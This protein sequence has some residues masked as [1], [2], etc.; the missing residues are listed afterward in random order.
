MLE[1]IYL[2]LAVFGVLLLAAIVAEIIV[3]TSKARVL[4]TLLS[5]AVWAA[6]SFAAQG[7]DV[8]TDSGGT[9]TQQ[10][11]VMIVLA[12]ALT[13]FSIAELL[14]AIAAKLSGSEGDD[15]VEQSDFGTAPP[16]R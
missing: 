15:P 9:V 13:L 4:L 11:P 2:F 6:V 1:S 7:I 5:T 12:G 10:E 8:V 3:D 16:S 14:F